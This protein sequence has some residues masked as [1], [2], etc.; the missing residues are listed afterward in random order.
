MERKVLFALDVSPLDNRTTK[1]STDLACHHDLYALCIYWMHSQSFYELFLHDGMVYA[2]Y[3]LLALSIL[4]SIPQSGFGDLD[5]LT[6][7][8]IGGCQLPQD[9]INKAASLWYSLAVDLLTDMLSRRY[10]SL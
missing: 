6:N 10:P 5:R 3:D 8:P 9:S 2:R 4:R 1:L 7:M